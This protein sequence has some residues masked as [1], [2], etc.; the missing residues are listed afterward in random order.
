S[1]VLPESLKASRYK[2]KMMH[3]DDMYEVWKPVPFKVGTPDY[4]V[5]TVTGNNV[6]FEA[7][8]ETIALSTTNVLVKGKV[9]KNRNLTVS[10]DIKNNGSE[11]YYAPININ[12][13]NKSTGYSVFTGDEI[14]VDILAGETQTIDIVNKI[15][16][17][18]GEYTLTISHKYGITIS[19]PID[20][21]V[22]PE[23]APAKLAL[24]ENIYFADNNNVPKDKFCLYASVK[25]SG[26][27]YNGTL[28]AYVYPIA[29]G[30]AVGNVTKSVE[31]DTNTTSLIEIKGALNAP[32]GMY[33]AIIFAKI[34][35]DFVKL[36]PYEY[37]YSEF[38]LVN[39]TGGVDEVTTAN[40]TMVYPNPATDFITVKSEKAITAIHI[41]DISG[42]LQISSKVSGIDI[43]SLSAGN[44][45]IQVVY[46]GGVDMKHF[47]KR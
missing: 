36:A 17:D 7:L 16:I 34:G 9:Y 2:I 46:D 39:G 30:T 43:S 27:V 20:I 12:L 32:E 14:V 37:N 35:N 4:I 45:L 5:A 19:T 26:G 31:I 40:G 29:G 42:T 13:S 33:K 3:K 41:F 8:S 44:Y 22:L 18:P 15:N 21:T 25:N 47:I 24:T 6:K 38:K 1:V 10:C 11:E 23:P 28:R